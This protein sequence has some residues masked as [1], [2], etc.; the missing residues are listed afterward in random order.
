VSEEK[1]EA[2]LEYLRRAIAEWK[3]WA[4]EHEIALLAMVLSNTKRRKHSLPLT[5]VG[6]AMLLL[7]LLYGGKRELSERIGMSRE[8]IREWCIM[9]GADW[10]ATAKRM[11]KKLERR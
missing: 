10:S 2:L 1:L 9:A 6:N 5:D 3:A 7:T 8:S 4:A 11:I